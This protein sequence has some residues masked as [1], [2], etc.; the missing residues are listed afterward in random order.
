LFSAG[1]GTAE[2]AAEK[3]W[4]LGGAAL[5]S[6]A[7]NALELVKALAAEVTEFGFSAACEVAPSPIRSVFP[8]LVEAAIEFLVRRVAIWGP[9][10]RIVV[11]LNDNSRSG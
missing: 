3:L 4:F 5:F 9:S 2:Q 11:R 1:C 6:A 10:I 8:H 7:V